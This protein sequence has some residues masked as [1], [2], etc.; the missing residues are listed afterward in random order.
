MPSTTTSLNFRA[1]AHVLP[2]PICTPQ[3]LKSLIKFRDFFTRNKV[4]Y[5]SQMVDW[6]TKMTIPAQDNVFNTLHLPFT[7]KGEVACI[8]QMQY[9]IAFQNETTVKKNNSCSLLKQSCESGLDL[10]QTT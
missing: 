1:T 7:K 8:C 5:E 2:S 10:L 6:I 9:L 4:E 3:P